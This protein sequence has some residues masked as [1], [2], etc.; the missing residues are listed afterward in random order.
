MHQITAYGG[1]T[2]APFQ[3]AIAQSPGFFPI[4][5]N[6]QQERIFQD[7][8]ALLEVDTIDEARQLPFSTLQN[9]KF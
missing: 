8:L 7:Y 6:Q 1:Q 3:Q 9:A 2:T 4:V 5:S